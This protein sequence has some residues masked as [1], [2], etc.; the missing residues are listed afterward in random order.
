M[1]KNGGMGKA[2]V[3]VLWYSGGG[4]ECATNFILSVNF[5]YMP[6]VCLLLEREQG[7]ERGRPAV[8]P[9]GVH[10]DKQYEGNRKSVI[11]TGEGLL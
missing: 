10:H 9:L 8:S 7:V 3:G 6:D 4:R 5:H 11:R 1:G 2:I